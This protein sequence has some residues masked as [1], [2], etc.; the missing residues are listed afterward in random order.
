MSEEFNK[1]QMLDN[2]SFLLQ[3]FSKK[4]GEL[5]AEAGVSP[6]YISRIT[7]DEKTK[8]GIDFIV[9]TADALNVSVDTLLNADFTKMTSTERYLVKLLRDRKSVV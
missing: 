7:K 9:K 6:G 5:E 3:E 8:P 4:I 2:I 1:K